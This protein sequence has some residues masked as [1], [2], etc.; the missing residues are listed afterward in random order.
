MRRR[1]YRFLVAFLVLLPGSLGAQ[2]SRPSGAFTLDRIP[3]HVA[4]EIRAELRSGAPNWDRVLR[5]FFGADG[6]DRDVPDLVVYVPR[7]GVSKLA[8][9]HRGRRVENLEGQ[10]FLYFVVFSEREIPSSATS[11]PQL[12]ISVRSIESADDPFLTALVKSLASRR[13][14]SASEPEL[15]SGQDAALELSLRDMRADTSSV[16]RLDVA[17]GRVRLGPNTLNRVTISGL[18]GFPLDPHVSLH[19]MFGN[20]DGSRFGV[21]I[22]S[23]F[24]LNVHRPVIESGA[25]TGTEG[26]LRSSFYLF[27]QVYLDRPHLPRDRFSLGVAVGTNV[28]RGDPMNDLVVG[29]AIGRVAGL[30]A[31]VGANSLEWRELVPG[32]DRVR[33][34]RRW[35]TFV[36]V[37]YRL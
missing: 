15:A 26:Y 36:G 2:Y 9:V 24:T 18:S 22:G 5:L 21:S 29:L 35:R 23:G 17:M 20:S 7:A 28:V 14:A 32:T 10:R 27:G 6:Y 13:G 16:Q 25:V 1:W 11:G 34:T 37:D 12:A 30:G 8:L 3:E 4:T 19:Y 33:D 31:I